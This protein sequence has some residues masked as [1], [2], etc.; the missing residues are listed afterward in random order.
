MIKKIY[1]LNLLNFLFF[2][3]V[4]SLR[5]VLELKQKEVGELRKA[6][7][8]ASQKAEILVGAEEKARFLN[9]RCEDLQLQL[10]R[11]SEY[12]QYVAI[13]LIYLIWNFF[14][15]LFNLSVNIVFLISFHII[16]SIR[17]AGICCKKTTS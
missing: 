1:V 2:Q 12:E 3:E 11:K 8:E 6:L 7:A 4:Q 13:L 9:A 15:F 10:Q 16:N 17:L 14:D 5:A